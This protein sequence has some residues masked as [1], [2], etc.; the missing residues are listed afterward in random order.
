MTLEQLRIFVAVAERE[1]V[2]RAAEALNLTQSAAS[3][4]IAALE[5]G[6]DVKLFHR[7]GR[8]IALTEAGRAFLDEARAVLARAQAARA[9]LDDIGTLRRGTLR[10]VASQTIAGYWLPPLVAR[11]R[12][13]HPAVMLNLSVG[14]SEEAARAVAEDDAELGFVEGAVLH[15]A[16]ARRVVAE[17]RLQIVT[18]RP[19][20]AGVD[21]DWLRQIAWVVREPGSGTRATLA[22]MLAEDGI[23]LD[24]LENVLV[25]PSNEAVRTAVEHGA[26]AAMLSDAVVAASVAAG[27]LHVQPYR[28]VSRPFYAL[29]H[30]ERYRSRAA[31]AFEAL[32]EEKASPSS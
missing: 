13:L 5:A 19:A 27:T 12:R 24:A 32:I 18:A 17:D 31:Q 6:H 3:A 9:V 20:T 14:N 2:T 29:H 21:R 25:L 1:H 30:K 7:A 22:D 10:L 26:G 23:A 15:P 11:F 4:A 28:P 8:G 16:L